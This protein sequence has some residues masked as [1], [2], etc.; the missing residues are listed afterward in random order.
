MITREQREE[1]FQKASPIAQK[2]YDAPESG[3][4]LFAIFEKYNLPEEKYKAYALSVGH[5]ILGFY[6]KA[7]LA[8]LLS[9]ELQIPMEKGAQIAADLEDFLA[10]LDESSSA[11][12][13]QA[14][15][16]APTPPIPQ[17]QK[18]LVQQP[19]RNANLYQ[20]PPDQTQ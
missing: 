15:P 20:K 10:P 7:Q 18:P 2:L 11:Q 6:T 14:D 8:Q 17:Y 13:P 12:G 1:R 16:V 9:Y 5:V 3:A 19:Y 4:Q